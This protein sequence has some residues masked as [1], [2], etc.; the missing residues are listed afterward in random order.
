MPWR[1]PASPAECSRRPPACCPEAEPTCGPSTGVPQSVSTRR[2]APTLPLLCPTVR[3]QPTCTSLG[4]STLRISPRRARGRRQAAAA[5]AARAAR[6]A[7]TRIRGAAAVASACARLRPAHSDA[8]ACA[9]GTRADALPPCSGVPAPKFS[10]AISVQRLY[11][12]TARGSGVGG[13][14]QWQWGGVGRSIRASTVQ[15]A[16]FGTGWVTATGGMRRPAA[17]LCLT[18]H[19]GPCSAPLP[20]PARQPRPHSIE[21]AGGDH[22]GASGGRE[23]LCPV[24]DA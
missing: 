22:G 17:V 1:R 18:A 14:Q 7:L 19:N 6:P 23:Q 24:T 11:L 9:G 21:A 13:D 8:Q 20:R 10:N 15:P 4:P 5:R 3:S 2:T 12:S 16:C